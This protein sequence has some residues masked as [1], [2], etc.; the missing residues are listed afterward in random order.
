MKNRIKERRE[1]LGISQTELSECS[2]VART[3]ISQLE[4]GSRK[5][6]TSDTMIKLANSLKSSIGEIFLS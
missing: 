2:G 6:V 4:N 3:V 5:T 1:E